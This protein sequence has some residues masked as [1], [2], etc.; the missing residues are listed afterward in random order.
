MCLKTEKQ[1]LLV[2]IDNALKIAPGRY[3][4]ENYDA[5]DKITFRVNGH[6]RMD[7][8]NE[9][10][11][12]GE[13]KTN[14]RRMMVIPQKTHSKPAHKPTG[15]PIDKIIA[16]MER[17][18]EHIRLYKQNLK[19][20]LNWYEERGYFKAEKELSRLRCLWDA[21]VEKKR[22]W[23]DTLAEL[24]NITKYH[25]KQNIECAELTRDSYKHYHVAQLESWYTAYPGQSYHV[26]K[27]YGV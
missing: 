16:E 7:I 1:T 27:V 6:C 25:F 3:F 8:F 9:R 10:G 26:I 22:T 4:R 21:C 15:K 12:L 17:E 19:E 14:V 5:P 11:V 24:G 23:K 18:I 20:N 13:V 2:E